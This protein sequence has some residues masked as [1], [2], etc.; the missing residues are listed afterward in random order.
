[1]DMKIKHL[2]FAVVAALGFAACQQEEDLGV[3]RIELNP[4]SLSF[5]STVSS[6]SVTLTATRDWTSQDVPDWIALDPSSGKASTQPQ[7]VNVT[8]IANAGN[9][10]ETDVVFTIGLSKQYLHVVQAGEKGELDKGDGT[11]EHPYTAS[12]AFEYVSSLPADTE[13]GPI[14]VRGVISNVSMTFEASGTYGNANFYISDD[15]SASGTQFYAFQ[16]YYLGN[17]KWT[18]GKTDIKVG[19]E[20]VLCGKVVNYKGNTPETVGKGASYIYSLNGV[21]EGGGDTDYSK[22]EPKTV[23]EFIKLAD[24][25]TYY[26][27]T[28][29]VSAFNASYCSFDLTDDTGKIYVYSV[30]NKSDWSSKIKNGGTVVLA[31]QYEYYASKSQHEVVNAQILSFEEGG[32]TQPG[33][34]KGSGTLEDPYNPAGAAAYATSLGSDVQSP[35]KVYIKGKISEVSTTFQASGNYGNANFTIVDSEDGSGSFYVFQTYY[36][37]NRQW[38]SG[39]TDVKVGDEVIVYGPVVNYKGNTPET[40]GKGASHIYSL[41]GKTAGGDQ[42]STD[43]PKGTG[44]QADPFNPAGAHAFVSALPADQNTP[45]TYYIKGVISH[46]KEKYG[47]QYGNASFYITED[48]TRNGTEFYAYHIYYLNNKQWTENDP[49][50]QVGD[51][52]VLCGKLVNY[53]GNTPETAD[54][55]AYLYSL[56][57]APVDPDKIDPA[58]CFY[59]NDFDKEAAQK[60]YGATASNYPYL[61]QFDGWKHEKG[62]GISNLVYTFNAVSARTTVPSTNG[63]YDASGSNNLFFG[64]DAWVAIKNIAVTSTSMTLSFGA[65][66]Y[67]YQASAI[68][69]PKD[70]LHA[71]VSVDD[72]KWVELSY[73]FKNP[74]QTTSD[75]GLASSTFTVPSGTTSVCVYF[76]ADKASSYRIDDISLQASSAAGTTL[77]FSKG[78]ELDTS[79]QSAEPLPEIK[80]VTVA[81]FL[82]AE[83][84][85]NQ[86]YQLTGTIGS[87]V[88]TSLGTFDLT[89]ETGTVYI[90][91]LTATELPYGSTNDNSFASLGLKSGD[92]IVINGYRGEYNGKAEMEYA[93]FIEKISSGEG[94]GDQPQTADVTVDLT[95][96][97]YTNAQAVSELK[98]GDLTLTF[99]QGSNSSYPP[100]YYDTGTAVRFY[101]GNTLTVASSGKQ[102]A[103][104]DLEFGSG[105]GKNEITATPGTF[106]DSHWE[107]PAAAATFK[108]EGTSGQRRIAKVLVKY[109]A[110]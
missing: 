102:I 30:A 79:D 23:A 49:Q 76:S 85:K 14:Y 35:N 31:G 27:L 12:A 50:I 88:N 72:K 86:R 38:T 71:Y 103:S 17:K 33:A 110:E 3:A 101:S 73:T 46:I 37:G 82:A 107:G 11:L 26:K 105:D 78:V 75:W 54:K 64:A 67:V 106:R 96:Q 61:D 24:T 9:N 7:T 100:K 51:K 80:K 10:R 5:G 18:S 94:G 91:G 65:N 93:Y 109:V 20:V 22:A 15:G 97:G 62:T 52:V 56:E 48:G 32:S 8:V 25:G 47:A 44:T 68:P 77:D 40:V 36:L 2:F 74:D 60:I 87:Q 39:D 90:Y 28:G 4:T 21:S 89:D 29:K 57:S 104:I 81:E 98:V 66:Y 99:S 45:D 69:F 70:G 92:K 108:I 58:K 1:M 42:P 34:A 43:T 19:D 41:N 95:A 59:Y 6:Q 53:K 55:E 13:S 84:S 63:T 83:K 16:T